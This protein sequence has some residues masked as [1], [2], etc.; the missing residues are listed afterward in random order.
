MPC[1][2]CTL[3]FNQKLVATAAL[4]AT[5]QHRH[6]ARLYFF[7]TMI[8]DLETKFHYTGTRL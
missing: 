6:A 8:D 4:S 7:L 1:G 2:Y 5:K 3:R